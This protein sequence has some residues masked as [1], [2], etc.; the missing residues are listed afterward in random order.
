LEKPSLLDRARFTFYPLPLGPSPNTIVDFI[1]TED[2]V[3]ALTVQTLYPVLSQIAPSRD[4]NSPVSFA[5]ID[6]AGDCDNHIWFGV[7]SPSSILQFGIQHYIAFAR[8]ALI[9][10]VWKCIIVVDGNTMV[11]PFIGSLH[12]GT[13][14]NTPGTPKDPP[15]LLKLIIKKQLY[16]GAIE[17]PDKCK[18]FALALWAANGPRKVSPQDPYLRQEVALVPTEMRTS[19]TLDA[20]KCQMDHVEQISVQSKDGPFPLVV[21]ERRYPDVAQL[22]VFPWPDVKNPKAQMTIRVATFTQMRR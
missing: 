18:V 14:F 4:E 22:A 19:T 7:P 8:E 9:V 3:Y 21:D 17:E 6:D 20:E 16:G 2:P 11:V 5:A 15:P 13:L 12:I 1:A 10:R